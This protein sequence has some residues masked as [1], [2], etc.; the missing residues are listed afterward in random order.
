MAYLNSCLDHPTG[1]VCAPAHPA[2]YFRPVLMS[3]HFHGVA[4]DVSLA[5]VKEIGMCDGIAMLAAYAAVTVLLVVRVCC[6][7]NKTIPLPHPRQARPNQ[8]DDSQP[9]PH[10]EATRHFENRAVLT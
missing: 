9:R 7:C 10:S 6:F 4:Q 3:P 2:A 5:C 8:N 1:M